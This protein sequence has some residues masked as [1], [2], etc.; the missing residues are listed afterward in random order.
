MAIVYPKRED[1]LIYEG[2]SF[3]AEWYYTVQGEMPAF[4]YYQGLRELDQDRLDYMIKYFCDRPYGQHLPLTMYRIEDAEKKIYAFKPRDE[5]FFNFTTEGAKVIVTN[6]Y[7]KHSQEMTKADHE[8][9]GMAARYRE[10]YLR[11]VKEATYYEEQ[12]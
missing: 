6:A 3:S 5:R 2:R 10:D 7:R 9:L 1:Y 12:N 11:R 8:E 4:E